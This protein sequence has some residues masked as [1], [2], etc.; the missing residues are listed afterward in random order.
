MAIDMKFG[1]PTVAAMDTHPTGLHAEVELNNGS[2]PVEAGKFTVTLLAKSADSS[3]SQAGAS[4]EVPALAAGESNH[5]KF[6]VQ[7]DPGEWSVSFTL[8][9]HDSGETISTDPQT[10]HIAGPTHH[11]QQFADSSKLQFD[12]EV[13]RVSA[14]GN[15]LVKVDYHLTNTGSVAILP[16]FPIDIALTDKDG[17]KF[18]QEYKI[19]VGVAKG[20]SEPKFLHVEA[21]NTAE[22][23]TSDLVIIGDMGGLAAREFH[24]KLTWKGDMT[25][26]IAPS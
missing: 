26:D 6:G 14:E 25:A 5:P 2:E 10:V 1:T 19:E 21:N 17:R 3:E 9:S 20:A 8:T 4:T 13:T 11:A 24:S 22:G 18:A 12:I 23:D 16:G 7:C 15:R